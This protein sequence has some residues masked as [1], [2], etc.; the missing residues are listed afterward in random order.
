M[1]LHVNQQGK[2]HSAGFSGAQY[3][4][5]LALLHVVEFETIPSPGRIGER[6]LYEGLNGGD[7]GSVGKIRCGGFS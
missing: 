7:V 1:S 3:Q 6:L 4:L 2:L 5:R